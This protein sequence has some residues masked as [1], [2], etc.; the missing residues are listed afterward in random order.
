MEDVGADPPEVSP[1]GRPHGNSGGVPYHNKHRLGLS[2]VP[3]S[4]SCGRF[5]WVEST[6][7]VHNYA[8]RFDPV[9]SSFLNYKYTHI[10]CAATSTIQKEYH[11]AASC[12]LMTASPANAGHSVALFCWRAETLRLVPFAGGR[13]SA[14]LPPQ[15]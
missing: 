7:Q 14:P 6:K 15:D 5:R 3:R 8:G 13:C 10:P 2:G 4:T 9:L 11:E 1:A 12:A